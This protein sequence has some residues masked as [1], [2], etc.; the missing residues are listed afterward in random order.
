MEEEKKEVVEE[1]KAEQAPEQIDSEQNLKNVLISFILAVA[2]FVV[3]ASAIVTL[4]LG[5]ISLNFLKKVPGQVTKAPHK[6]FQKIAKPVAIV[7]IVLGILVTLAYLIWL[8]VWLIMV[9]VA[10]TAAAQ[11]A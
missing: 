10:A 2:G 3:S 6:V 7:D 4:V 5:I 8:I 1:V 11:G 9:A